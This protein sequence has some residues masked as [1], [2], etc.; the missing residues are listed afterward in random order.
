MPDNAP[1]RLAAIWFADIVGYTD[2]S[3]RD[4]DL[5]LRLVAELQTT[6]EREVAAHS[7]RIVKFLGDAVLATFPSAGGAV[8]AA[9]A[10]RDAF[11]GST[12]AKE[13]K[14][15][16]RTGIHVGEIVSPDDGDVYGDGVNTASRI[17]RS[18]E[19]G[20]VLLSAFAYESIRHRSE[21]RTEM[22]G[23]KRLRG[24]SRPTDLYSVSLASE[25]EPASVGDGKDATARASVFSQHSRAISV[26]LV[27]GMAGLIGLGIILGGQGT[28]VVG[29]MALPMPPGDEASAQLSLGIEAYYRDDHEAVATHLGLFL[30]PAGTM[31]ERRR[32][33]R[34]LARSLWKAGR[35]EAVREVLHKLLE[36]EPPLALLIPSL[37][38]D[39]MMELYY[40]ARREQMANRGLHQ[41]SQSVRGLLVF[42]FQMFAPAEMIESGQ[43]PADI[44]YIMAFMLET[45][46]ELAGIPVS[47][48]QE[49]SF[50]NR[51]DDAYDDLET[52]LGGVGGEGPSHLLT[53]SVVFGESGVLLS[54]WVYELSTGSLV[55][56][57]QVTGRMDTL[58][59]LPETIAE[60][61]A[62][63]LAQAGNGA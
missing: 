44:G 10:V 1:S 7:G 19:P 51:G 8:R 52:T 56:P 13:A 46:L 21:F 37:E 30:K 12:A 62:T 57:D 50:E 3:A 39:S 9:L 20:Q 54:T 45:D 14:A 2:L 59:E 16:L 48:V 42:D 5:A 40:D 55:L 49:M 28:P 29:D 58:L 32:G 61:L 63:S 17:E 47:N 24:L 35:P 22:V 36:T 38:P 33:L 11:T 18:A 27:A 53:G 6:S 34:Y 41:S 25:P 43:I 4:E 15:S 60:R 23:R 31:A 26:G